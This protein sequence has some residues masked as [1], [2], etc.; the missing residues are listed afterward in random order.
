[1]F[2]DLER[3]RENIKAISDGLRGGMHVAVSDG[4]ADPRLSAFLARCRVET[5]E[6]EICLSEVPL[7]E[8]VRGLRSGDFV[9]G[10]AH[11]ADASH[12]AV[13][14][15]IWR[16]PLML[17]VPAR[18]ELLAHAEVPLHELVHYP[19]ML[20]DPHACKGRWWELARLLDSLK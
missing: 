19:L 7:V 15:P 1:M 16:D 18:H 8:Q 20:C 11:T 17:A 12:G 3:A 5:S 10:F 9:M 14:E 13:A 2:L 4:T 6:I